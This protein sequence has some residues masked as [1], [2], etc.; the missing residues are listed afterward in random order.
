MNSKQRSLAKTKENRV[1]MDS[2][3]RSRTCLIKLIE[4]A[5]GGQ[6]A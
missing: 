6:D 3:G 1:I 4:T 2:W 5:K